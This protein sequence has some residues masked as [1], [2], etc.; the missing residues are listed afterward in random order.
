MRIYAGLSLALTVR[1]PLPRRRSMGSPGLNISADQVSAG[2]ATGSAMIIGRGS[3]PDVSLVRRISLD[4]GVRISGF[5][6]ESIK[7]S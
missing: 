2:V 3:R 7:N 5:T 1:L 6:V 4:E